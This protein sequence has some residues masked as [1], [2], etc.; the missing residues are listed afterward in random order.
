MR[1]SWQQKAAMWSEWGSA[2]S[3]EM[4]RGVLHSTVGEGRNS[5]G[6]NH[7]A[8][9]RTARME[10]ASREQVRRFQQHSSSLPAVP[11]RYLEQ[12]KRPKHRFLWERRKKKVLCFQTPP[13][14]GQ[15]LTLCRFTGLASL[16]GL[17]TVRNAQKVG[18]RTSEPG[19]ATLKEPFCRWLARTQLS[20]SIG[21]GYV[22]GQ[23]RPGS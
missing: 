6:D 17:Q 1:L 2:S 12:L 8:L 18:V 13:P 21:G 15:V 11:T 5:Q 7:L 4:F 22:R 3:R 23:P 16:W 20:T 9:K 14:R 19:S 10:A